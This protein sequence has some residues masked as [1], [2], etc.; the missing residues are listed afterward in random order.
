MLR[1]K[2]S[3]NMMKQPKELQFY[4]RI[5]I[6]SFNNSKKKTA[7]MYEL[8]KEGIPLNVFIEVMGL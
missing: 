5:T 3:S 1:E 7:L 8:M 4:D 2:K 6:Q